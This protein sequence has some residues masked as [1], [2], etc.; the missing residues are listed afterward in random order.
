[1]V[2]KD[3]IVPVSGWLPEPPEFL[4]LAPWIVGKGSKQAKGKGDK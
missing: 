2:K 3:E 4:K 1:M